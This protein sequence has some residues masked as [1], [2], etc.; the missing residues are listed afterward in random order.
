M[1]LKVT[2]A[3][4]VL[5]TPFNMSKI[6]VDAQELGGEALLPSLAALYIYKI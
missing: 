1:F 4:E 5:A 6:Q 3:A 2:G